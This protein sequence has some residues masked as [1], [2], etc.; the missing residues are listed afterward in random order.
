MDLIA[1]I[2]RAVHAIGMRVGD[3]LDISQPEALLLYFLAPKGIAPLEAVHH[4][5]L[6]RRSTLTN[7]LERLER[8]GLVERIAS[9]GDRRRF[10]IRLTRSG[11]RVAGQVTDLFERI[12]QSAGASQR[13]RN[14]AAELLGKIAQSQEAAE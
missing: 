13:D 12:V 11:R 7:V 8:R 5:F 4:A 2:H 6:H 14:A 1:Q 9:A 3:E 10:D